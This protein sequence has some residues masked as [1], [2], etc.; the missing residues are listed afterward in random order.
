MN[1]FPYASL[2]FEGPQKRFSRQFRREVAK[3]LG[4]FVSPIVQTP[5]ALGEIGILRGRGHFERAGLSLADLGIQIGKGLEVEG[6]PSFLWCS[7]E[8]TFKTKKH[9]IAGTSLP[10][11]KPGLI[12]KFQTRGDYLFV[13]R[14]AVIERIRPTVGLQNALLEDREQGV[15]RRNDQIVTAVLKAE[16]FVLLMAESDTAEIQVCLPDESPLSIVDADL[17]THITH[18]KGS[19]ADFSNELDEGNVLFMSLGR[20]RDLQVD[21]SPVERTEPPHIIETL[22]PWLEDEELFDQ[23]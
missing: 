6:S 20:V 19:I 14:N 18:R 17:D 11:D 23:T 16:R 5:V 4:M 7:S 1:G 3:R 9:E 12:L 15:L 2:P 8:M 13:A 10:A 22:S 21:D